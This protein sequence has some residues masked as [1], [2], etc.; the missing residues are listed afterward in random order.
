MT[1]PDHKLQRLA[2]QIQRSIESTLIGE[3]PEEVLQNLEVQKVE[4]AAGNRMLVTLIAHPP[5]S[6]MPKEAVLQ[7]LETR[8][9][10]IVSRVAE[11]VT[12]HALPEL[13]FWVVREPIPGTPG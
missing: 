5:G 12:R 2:A 6:E 10:L 13:T 7:L 11:D 1:R 8:R 9:N 4:P 3:C